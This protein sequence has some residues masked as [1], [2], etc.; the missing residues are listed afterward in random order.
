M[1]QVTAFSP[2]YLAAFKDIYEHEHEFV[3]SLFDLDSDKKIFLQ[4]IKMFQVN[5]LEQYG[6]QADIQDLQ[7]Q[8]VEVCQELVHVGQMKYPT[9]ALTKRKQYLDHKLKV[10]VSLFKKE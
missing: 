9:D 1:I 5:G 4:T 8:I 10:F 3:W 2:L 7:K 6:K